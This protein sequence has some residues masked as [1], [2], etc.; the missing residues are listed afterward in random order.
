VSF[1]KEL[2]RRNVVRV[3]IAYV[4][5][6]WL[7]LQLTE[8]LSELLK[9]PDEI[10]PIVVAIVAIGLPIALFFAWAYELTPE[11][12]KRESEIDR[13]QSITTQTGKKLNNAILVL[14][15]LAIT[16][17][18]Y[19]KFSGGKPAPVSTPDT[20]VA[21]STPAQETEP[22][23]DSSTGITR[24]SI[25]V[26]PFDNRSNREE[27]QFFVDGIHDDLLTTIAK[28]GSM[29]V[30]SR[31]S[32]MEYKDTTKK[33]PEIAT[34]LGVANILEGGIQRAGNQVRINVQLIDANT[35]EHLW[36]EIYDRELS[37]ENLF[38]I[39]SEI[40]NAIAEALK[41]TLTP[42][43]QENINQ[44][45]TEN[46][47]AYNAYLRG[48]QEIPKRTVEALET[49]L[50][51][52]TRAVELDPEFSL[53]WVGVAESTFLLNSY[54]T[55][56]IDE[57]LPAM[58]AAVEKALELDPSS[59][60]AYATLAQVHSSREQYAEA[61]TAYKR[62]IEL[63]PNYAT[64]W[65]WYAGFKSGRPPGLREAVTL[66]ERALELDP[67]SSI[68][69]TQ[70]AGI[71]R[72]LG[73]YNRVM[74]LTKELIDLDPDFPSSYAQLSWMSRIH[75]GRYDEAYRYG[76]EALQR[77]EGSITRHIT[78]YSVLVGVGSLRR[79]EDLLQ[80]T[81]DFDPSSYAVRSAQITL[82]LANGNIPGAIELARQI[83]VTESAPGN[84][85]EKG[86][87]MAIAGE[88][89]RAREWVIYEEQDYIDR[90]QW[91]SLMA[92]WSV[93]ACDVAWV[94]MQTG[95]EQ[96]GR[97]LID[98][99]IEYVTVE[100]PR[101]I[102][103]TERHPLTNCYAA[104]GDVD[105]ALDELQRVADSN[106][107]FV[108]RRAGVWPPTRILVNE[109]RYAEIMREYEARLEEQ[110]P[111]VEALHDEYWTSRL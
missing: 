25:A 60:E 39:Q 98:R 99:T 31:T 12:V 85:Y 50:A 92:Q 15:A 42:E 41:A 84:R 88:Y 63:S 104:L 33:I 20:E 18:L 71:Y 96:L 86:W 69:R 34:E 2:K 37:I 1:L 21:V 9:L 74:T 13:S 68:L 47:A 26:L 59:G 101:Y 46:L 5:G 108:F 49:A 97:D 107:L 44:Q 79:A 53:A 24:Q 28:I 67:L 27:D 78:L 75:L 82:A 35:D 57:S 87:M 95:D 64:A 51:E 4:V 100:L 110:R 36:A 30:I 89:E 61:E 62:A 111:L 109:P 14:M 22:A 6:G 80:F 91:D 56:S 103:H 76:I 29:K 77:D 83:E 43:E 106:Q 65:H 32:V 93:D 72:N 8:V 17:L 102:E 16:Y 45:P 90:S 11:G 66:A 105:S 94:L 55:L 3:G 10:G 81:E 73:E 48:R 70:L 38:A 58:E 23:P 54:G 19:D 40:S 7:L 52:F